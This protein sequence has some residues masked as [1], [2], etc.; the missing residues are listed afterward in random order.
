MRITASFLTASG[1]AGARLSTVAV[2]AL[3]S[4]GA[5]LAACSGG[6]AAPSPTLSAPASSTTLRAIRAAVR[7]AAFGLQ[8]ASRHSLA[9]RQA[10]PRQAGPVQSSARRPRAVRARLETRQTSPETARPGSL[11]AASRPA[12]VSGSAV[13]MTSAAPRSSGI[14]RMMGA[15]RTMLPAQQYPISGPAQRPGREQLRPVFGPLAIR[16]QR[17]EQPAR[18]AALGI[19]SNLDRASDLVCH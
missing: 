11:R 9:C 6:A 8:P 18:P 16:Q 4:R 1:A 7:C 17:S 3:N 15:A 13:S 19:F 5:R 2:H 10:R 12:L 14:T